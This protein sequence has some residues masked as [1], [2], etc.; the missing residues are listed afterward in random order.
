MVEF[1]SMHVTMARKIGRISFGMAIG[2]I[3]YIFDKIYT[4][5]LDRFISSETGNK[6]INVCQSFIL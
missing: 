4:T 6:I 3:S 1:V 5:D 2:G